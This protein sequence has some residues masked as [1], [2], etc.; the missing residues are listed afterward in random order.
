ML[1]G[2]AGSPYPAKYAR[3]AL[4]VFFATI[5]WRSS[6]V[7]MGM[8]RGQLGADLGGLLSSIRTEFLPTG[9]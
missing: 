1:L 3:F 9:P 4:A 2:P 5:A 6:H 7:A 8:I